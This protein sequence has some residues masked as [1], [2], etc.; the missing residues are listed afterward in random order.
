MFFPGVLNNMQFVLKMSIIF[1]TWINE[2]SEKVK[3]IEMQE[4][5]V[6]PIIF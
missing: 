1:S 3:K 4:N 2:F 5:D 6:M